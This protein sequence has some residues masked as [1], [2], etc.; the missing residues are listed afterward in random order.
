MNLVELTEL[1]TG[2]RVDGTQRR[3]IA[4]SSEPVKLL[5]GTIFHF[6]KCSQCDGVDLGLEPRGIKVLFGRCSCDR[7]GDDGTGRRRVRS[8]GGGNEVGTEWVVRVDSVM[9]CE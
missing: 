2:C 9:E 7:V 6:A 5:P 8:D 4:A 1:F 3:S